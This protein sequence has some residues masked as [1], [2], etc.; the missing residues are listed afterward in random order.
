MDNTNT[1]DFS[2]SL[3]EK[4]QRSPTG[5]KAP[6]RDSLDPIQ[7]YNH[8]IQSYNVQ[9]NRVDEKHLRSVSESRC[10][11]K[12]W[13]IFRVPLLLI[14]FQMLILMPIIGLIFYLW[15]LY[16]VIAYFRGLRVYHSNKLVVEDP[17]QNMI[18]CPEICRI[19]NSIN[20]FYE[21]QLNGMLLI[22][23]IFIYSTTYSYFN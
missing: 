4:R 8:V 17:F 21:I 12:F 20:K 19:T 23:A 11:S 3:I 6:V 2:G 16:S 18:F 13:R 1:N 7:C 14:F 22:V 9:E 10:Y 15:E 5:Y